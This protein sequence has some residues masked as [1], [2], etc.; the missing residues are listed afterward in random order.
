MLLSEYAPY[1]AG[2]FLIGAVSGVSTTPGA[3]AFTRTPLPPSSLAAAR[4]SCT[5]PA[6]VIA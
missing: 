2:S 5:M 6:F 1:Q 3:S 4:T